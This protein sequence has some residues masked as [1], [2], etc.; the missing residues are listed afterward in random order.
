[1]TLWKFQH[2]Q[3]EGYILSGPS[4]LQPVASYSIASLLHL[5]T[6]K[7]VPILLSTLEAQEM[8]QYTHKELYIP[9]DSEPKLAKQTLVQ[10]RP[11]TSWESATVMS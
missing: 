4:K 7:D 5:M 8:Y 1:M 11:N 10:H 2:M 6:Q 9:S 3:K